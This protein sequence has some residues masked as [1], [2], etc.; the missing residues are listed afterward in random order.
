MEKHL[1]TE[2]AK[3]A[4]Q[5][6]RWADKSEMDGWSTH[7]VTPMRDKAKEIYALLGQ[8]NTR[9]LFSGRYQPKGAKEAELFLLNY[10]A[11]ST[12]EDMKGMDWTTS[13]VH[14]LLGKFIRENADGSHPTKED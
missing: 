9:D 6:E 5:L 12:W 7:Q 10:T 3:M 2:L 11:S 4:E 14:E 13:D 8:L 1:M